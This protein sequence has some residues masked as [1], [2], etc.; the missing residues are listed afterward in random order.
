MASAKDLRVAPIAAADAVRM[1]KATHYSGRVVQNSQVHLGVFLDGRL[2]GAMQFGPSLDKRKIQGLVAGTPWHGFI[3]L[4][5]MAFSDRLPRNSESRAMAVAFRLLR[6]HYPQLEWVIS[7]ADATQCGDGT[8]YRAAGFVLTA[9][10]ANEQIVEFPDGYRDT[11]MVLTDTSGPKR[12]DVA[13]RYGVTLGGA[14]TL[15][16][17]LDIG[18]RIVPGHQLRYIYFLKPE[19]RAR[20]T[21]PIVPFGKI[22][23]VG[24]GMYR[25]EKRA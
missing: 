23:E 14:A 18:A 24:A 6:K 4:N 16:P 13:R 15:K 5:R 7:F 2:E 12:H 1:V 17:F 21:V 8:I 9:I 25:G 20:L 10:K 11:R 3:E 22:A 19:A